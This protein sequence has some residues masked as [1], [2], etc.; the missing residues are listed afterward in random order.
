MEP[1]TLSKLFGNIPTTLA[2]KLIW[3]RNINQEFKRQELVM[4]ETIKG[5]NT[6]VSELKES[7]L[8]AGGRTKRGQAQEILRLLDKLSDK[9]NQL[10]IANERWEAVKEIL[11]KSI[12]QFVEQYPPL[13]VA[14]INNG[15][16]EPTDP[17]I[18]FFR[19]LKANSKV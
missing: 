17:T 3:E 5:L 10:A 1:E 7:I 13:L 2:E 15:L 11:T 18:F 6:E 9:T 12:K 14:H 19:I 4:M 16:P 8:N